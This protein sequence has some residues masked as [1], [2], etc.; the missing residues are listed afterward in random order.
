MMISATIVQQQLHDI[1][2][3]VLCRLP[4]CTAGARPRVDLFEKALGN[5]CAVAPRCSAKCVTEAALL[6]SCDPAAAAAIFLQQKLDRC[7]LIVLSS[8]NQ[9]AVSCKDIAVAPSH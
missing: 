2:G 7:E 6:P 8:S 4:E 9:A 1:E 3:T 5:S